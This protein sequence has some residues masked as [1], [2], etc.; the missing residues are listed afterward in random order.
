MHAASLTWPALHGGGA[1]VPIRARAQLAMVGGDA[2]GQRGTG[3]VLHAQGEALPVPAVRK[4]WALR[5]IGAPVE[6][7]LSRGPR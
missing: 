6:R 3:A 2:G 4:V 7:R 1:E 5:V